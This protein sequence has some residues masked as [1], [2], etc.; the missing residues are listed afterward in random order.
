MT[1]FVLNTE[2]IKL[3]VTDNSETVSIVYSD[4]KA[5][6]VDGYQEV[7]VYIDEARELL[8]M[9]EEGQFGDLYDTPSNRVTV[10]KGFEQAILIEQIIDVGENEKLYDTVRIESD[11]KEPIIKQLK[12]VVEANEALQL[13]G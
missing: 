2:E 1:V 12:H 9:L 10:R 8:T 13:E 4:S 11:H 6:D 5:K 7:T 3:G